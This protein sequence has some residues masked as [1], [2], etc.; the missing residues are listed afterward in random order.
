MS[1]ARTEMFLRLLGRRVL[2]K[3]E[4][5]V[6]ETQTG[7]VLPSE[8]RERPAMGIIVCLGAKADRELKLGQEVLFSK[9]HDRTLN[10]GDGEYLI[11]LDHELQAR[12]I[13]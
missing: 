12:I 10:L 3:R 7:L 2:V 8:A 6:N 9:W 1:Q 4:G 13:P 5:E 11:F